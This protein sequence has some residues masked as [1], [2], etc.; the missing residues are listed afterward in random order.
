MVGLWNRLTRHQDRNA[1]FRLVRFE[2]PQTR[3]GLR[4]LAEVRRQ[5]LD[6]FVEGLFGTAESLDLPER[7]HRALN[8]ISEMR[9][10]FEGIRMLAADETKAATPSEITNT[11]RHVRELTMVGE[12]EMHEAVLACTRARRKLLRQLRASKPVLH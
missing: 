1:P 3:E 8:A 6:G 9:A 11:M 7:A 4:H 10:M 2:V 12:H 5:E